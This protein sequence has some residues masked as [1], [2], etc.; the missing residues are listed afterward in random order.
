M[1][2]S[3]PDSGCGCCGTASA[4]RTEQPVRAGSA[5]RVRLL[6]GAEQLGIG[7]ED[8]GGLAGL[9]DGG[10]C[11]AVQGRMAQLV[12]GRLAATEARIVELVE[13][14]ARLQAG[15]PD[16]RP[17]PLEE[18]AGLQRRIVEL[19]GMVGVLQGAAAR[20]SEPATTGACRED[21]ACVTA[22]SAVT[23]PR[24]PASRMALSAAAVGGG[25]DI[26]CT[27]EGGTDAMSERITD[28]QT[29]V[30]AATGREPADGGVTL[31]FDHDPGAA[32]E[33][34]RLAAAEFACCS[35]FTFTLTIGPM[36]MRFTVTAPEE[37]RDVVTAVYGTA[38]PAASGG[39]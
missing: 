3:V 18:V 10:D 22:A 1:S 12:T 25:S 23:T 21:C 31:T 36:G 6:A 16:A 2:G 17:G 28:W 5:V 32:V 9:F 39:S 19:G 14:A 34:A 15:M 38:A 33:L 11:A 7:G 8:L 24:V 27:L 26:V 4:E 20:L 35:F 13:E 37:A 30:G 29:V